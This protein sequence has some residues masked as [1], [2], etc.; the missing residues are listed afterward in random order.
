[1]TEAALETVLFL[2]RGLDRVQC[3]I[4]LETFDG[5]DLMAVGL[6]CEHGARL[7]WFSVEQYRARAT[8]GRVTADVRTG[9]PGA[10]ADVVG[11]EH[12]RLDV[13]RG[14][15]AVDADVNFHPSTPPEPA[16]PQRQAPGA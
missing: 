16:R 14:R 15:R 10:S 7:H 6:H 2:E 3:A 12:S 8:A 1:R 5:R 4:A 9:E 13:V 11:E